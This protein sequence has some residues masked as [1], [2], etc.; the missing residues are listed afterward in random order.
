[1]S[2]S[3]LGFGNIVILTFEN[4]KKKKAKTNTH[5]RYNLVLKLFVLE[6]FI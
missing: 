4:E 3:V 2:Y 5:F 6:V 1:M